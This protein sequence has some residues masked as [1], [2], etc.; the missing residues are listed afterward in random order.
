[1]AH[2]CLEQWLIL[3]E[4][5]DWNLHQSEGSK[6]HCVEK[7]KT[8][9][10]TWKRRALWRPAHTGEEGVK[11]LHGQSYPKGENHPWP[12]A[13]GIL[14]WL[15]TYEQLDSVPVKPALMLKFCVSDSLPRGRVL[16]PV[17]VLADPSWFWLSPLEKGLDSFPVSILG[18]DAVQH[19]QHCGTYSVSIWVIWPHSWRGELRV[20]TLAEGLQWKFLLP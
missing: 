18:W 16:W 2:Q 14:C 8:C 10:W 11:L 17:L 5:Q 6:N 7:L 15:S 20:S 19:L 3:K 1:M 9:K 4:T 13:P 12:Q